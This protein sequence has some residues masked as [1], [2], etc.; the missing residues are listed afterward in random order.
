LEE[1][2]ESAKT[3]DV[4]RMVP[5]LPTP[6]P[7]PNPGAGTPADSPRPFFIQVGNPHFTSST[8]RKAVA[9]PPPATPETKPAV[10]VDTWDN[11]GS[12]APK[13]GDPWRGGFNSKPEEE[14]PWRGFNVKPEG[15]WTSNS[16]AARA[17]G[18]SGSGGGMRYTNIEK[19]FLHHHLLVKPN[20]RDDPTAC[21]GW[22]KFWEKVGRRHYPDLQL[23][24]GDSIKMGS[25]DASGY[26]EI[27]LL[28]KLW[29]KIQANIQQALES[30]VHHAFEGWVPSPIFQELCALGYAEANNLSVSEAMKPPH[31]D[32]IWKLLA[33]VQAQPTACASEADRNGKHNFPVVQMFRGPGESQFMR[34]CPSIRW[35]GK[36][37]PVSAASHSDWKQSDKNAYNSY[38]SNGWKSNGWN[39][40]DANS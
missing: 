1:S 3:S 7:N 16:S 17:S 5:V 30:D 19:D 23:P 33:T 39:P 22:D 20:S 40:V 26:S 31:I 9:P 27:A 21:P 6:P 28:K 10:T 34:I 11:P 12:T 8:K 37:D 29:D 38:G 18:H 15:E 25:K 14:S 24:R 36:S 4:R 35:P 13:E 2:Q 32:K